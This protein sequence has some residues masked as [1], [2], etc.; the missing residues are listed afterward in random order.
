[1][2]ECKLSYSINPYFSRELLTAVNRR[3]IY[4]LAVPDER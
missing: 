2:V 3:A 4:I 1:M